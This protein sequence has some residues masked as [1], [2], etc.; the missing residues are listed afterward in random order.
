MTARRSDNTS[1]NVNF[2]VDFPDNDRDLQI[3]RYRRVIEYVETSKIS[4]NI[5]TPIVIEDVGIASGPPIKLV[6]ARTSPDRI[7]VLPFR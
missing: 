1:L 6:I 5:N 7:A 3:S 2:N 4:K